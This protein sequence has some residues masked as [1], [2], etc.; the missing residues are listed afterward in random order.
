M[1]PSEVQRAIEAAR[2]TTSA[3]GLKA[4]NGVVIHNSNR[5]AVRLTPCDVLARVAPLAHQAGAEFEVELGR[6]LAEASCPVEKPEA[7]VEPR[8]YVRDGFA[9]TLW[10]YYEAVPP[11]DIAPAEYA[12]A[13]EQ[14]H[15]C[16]RQID[17]TVPHFTDRVAE[18]QRLVGDPAQT[19][20]L[21]DTGRKLLGDTL[22]GLRRAIVN[23][24]A[25]E[26][27]LHGEPHPGNL[28]NTKQGLLLID[29]ETCCR[30]P[31]EFD[32][33][34]APEDVSEHYPT[35]KQDLLRECRV[36]V[37]AMVT[38]WRW[39]RNDQFPDGRYWGIEGINQ[40]RIALDRYGMDVAD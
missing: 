38:A 20:E 24:R 13:L 9:I 11:Q 22:R 16:V 37:L 35:I 30:G 34:H 17:L 8:V 2:S 36:L 6:R 21:D 4:D 14:Y 32:I 40:V 33:A 5:I 26:Q 27:L 7:R 3:L 39:D 12:Q 29:L 10:T 1:E 28:L 15:A 31:V 19:P 25:P 23:R 18:A